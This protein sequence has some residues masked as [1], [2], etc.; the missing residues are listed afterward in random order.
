MKNE[1]TVEKVLEIKVR[2]DDAI[3]N[4]AKY[5]AAVRY[6]F[7]MADI[8]LYCDEPTTPEFSAPATAVR[9]LLALLRGADMT[10]QLTVLAK[11]GLC[12]L[13]EEQ[14]CALENYAYTWS[15]NAAAWRAEFTKNPKGFGENELTDEDR[16]NLAWAEDARRKL[17]DAVDTLRGKVKGG[18]AEQISRAV[19]FCLKELGAE[20]QQAGL[21]E[22]IRAARGIPAAEEAAREWN[23]VMQLLDEMASLLGQQSV[24]VAE[25]EDLFGLLLRSSWGISPRRWT[26]WCWPAR[27]RCVWT[28]RTMCSCWGWQKGSFPVHRPRA[29]C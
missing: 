28:R 16:Q 4:I 15:P 7:R 9:A 12:A 10:E 14:V 8:P 23:V 17:V 6:E 29:A 25:Y 2:Y 5:R 19:Y 20:E 22:D 21:V 18:N 1:N 13:S 27:A 24:T 3:R 26:P 11:T